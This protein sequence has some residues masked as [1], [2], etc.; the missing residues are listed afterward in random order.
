MR[1]RMLRGGAILSLALVALY[2]TAACGAGGTGGG[3]E[4]STPTGGGQQTV[5]IP[6]VSTDD[7]LAAMV[8]ESVKSDGKITI[9][10]DQ[11]YPPNEFV[12]E[13]NEVVGM[14]VDLGRAIGQKLG[15][16]VEYVNASFDGLI[17][18]LAAKK[19]E[20]G[21]SSF[22]INEE[23]MQ[24][25]DMVSYFTAGTAMAVRK[26]NPDN[27]SL[28]NL[29][30]KSV[31]VQK[32]T[33]Q[34]EDLQARSKEC[35]QAGKPAIKIQQLQ[36]QTDVNLALVS[37]RVQAMLADSPVVDYAVVQTKGQV[38]VVGQ[39]Y[40]NAPYGI[41]IPKGMGKF[42]ESVRGAVQ[43]L[44]DDGTYE[45]ILKKWNVQRGAIEKAELNPQPAG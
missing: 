32:G 15:L 11:T 45:A 31:G 18:G 17:A 10:H 26:G 4:Q 30:G 2:G 13:Q 36:N 43:S 40:D 16:E 28:D 7:K 33:I 37:K 22:T 5:E 42:A 24:Q 23:R 19:Y 41:A 39:S 38:E 1:R 3:G 44:M 20:M 25:V 12:N 27:L 21:N 8:P 34:V 9:G 35:T 29:C 14:N 6:E